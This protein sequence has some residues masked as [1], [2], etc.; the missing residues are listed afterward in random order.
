MPRSSSGPRAHR[1]LAGRGPVRT[2]SQL[3]G[4]AGGELRGVAVAALYAAAAGCR[5]AAGACP[6]TRPPRPRVEE[7]E[8]GLR[9]SYD[10]LC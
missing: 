6:P 9:K 5:S 3:K 4:P 7:G 8:R 1:P 2:R 10:G